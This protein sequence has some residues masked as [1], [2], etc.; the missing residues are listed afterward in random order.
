MLG[1]RNIHKLTFQQTLPFVII[2]SRT[3]EG[4]IVSL[5]KFSSARFLW[6]QQP[7]GYASWGYVVEMLNYAR[8]GEAMRT[9]DPSSSPITEASSSAKR[10][11]F[12]NIHVPWPCDLDDV[13]GLWK[14]P[15][16]TTFYNL[17][18]L[19]L[20]LRDAVFWLIPILQAT[21]SSAPLRRILLRACDNYMMTVL[22]LQFEELEEI[23]HRRKAVKLLLA[24]ASTDDE[25]FIKFFR[26]RLRNIDKDGRIG[27]LYERGPKCKL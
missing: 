7:V 6:I 20:D 1:P 15:L 14:Y 2:R 21:H 19:D 10:V 17:K 9:L 26:R 5:R 11:E 8:M 13:P 24:W 12:S 3:P 27:V 16:D 18:V 4:M 25:P 23:L 22:P